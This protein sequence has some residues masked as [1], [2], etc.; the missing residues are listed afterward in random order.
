M[1]TAPP[2]VPFPADRPGGATVLGKQ[3][4]IKG[5]IVGREDLTIEGNVE[6]SI[7]LKEHRLTVGPHGSVKSGIKAREVIIF[8]N[9][10]GKI[11]ASER[12]E[13]RSAATLV[14]DIRTARVL[15]EDGA[16]FKGAVD[17]TKKDP[18]PPI[19]ALAEPR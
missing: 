13:I 6:G 8:G 18:G 12:I 7:E 17:I 9:V 3:V 10:Q 19:V 1:A 4:T 16:Y 11:E 15:I 14:G 5:Q 2:R